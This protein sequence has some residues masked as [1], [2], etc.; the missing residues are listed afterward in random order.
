[1]SESALNLGG[2]KW[3]SFWNRG[4][5]WK[6]LAFAVV[7][8][9]LYELVPLAASPF[10]GG[11]I[12][13]DNIFATPQ[14]IFV[15]VTLGLVIGSLILAAFAWSVGWLP[16]PLFA[17]QPVKGSR[18]MWIAPALVLA[19]IVLRLFGTDY[20]R[21]SAGVVAMMFVTGAF[22]GFSEELLTRGVAVTLLRRRGYGEWAVAALSSLIFALLHSVNLL[23]GQPLS[24]VAATV[25][26]TFAFG[27]LMYLTLRVTGNLVWP[28]LLHAL[29]DPATMLAS[30]GIDVDNSGT[31]NPLLSAAGLSTMLVIA[32]GFIL[33]VFIRGNARGRASARELPL[34]PQATVALKP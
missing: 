3:K 30:G 12:D 29:T 7:Y 28:M 32:A 6:A 33:L 13:N 25:G 10:L 9:A 22:V 26:Y 20:G 21:Y 19:P 4:G 5:W 8:L 11:A 17:R 14:S 16:R 15:A 27:M 31:Q 18:W 34:T 2:S 24:T 23:S 1:M